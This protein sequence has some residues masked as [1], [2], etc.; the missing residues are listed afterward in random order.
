MMN[1]QTKPKALFML[2]LCR[3]AG[4]SQS[5]ETLCENA[6]RRKKVYL[7]L[8]AKDASPNTYKKFHDKCS[9]YSV[10]VMD[11]LFSKEELGAAM[12]QSERSCVAI[13]EQGLAKGLAEVL[14]KM[15][16]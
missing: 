10:P 1:K 16:E 14:Q 6:I 3:K 4:V 13:C 11:T 7:V 12:G 2:G 5:G 8:L 15:H 9:F